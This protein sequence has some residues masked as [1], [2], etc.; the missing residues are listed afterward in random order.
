MS[1]TTGT[2]IFHCTTEFQSSSLTCC[3]RKV[4]NLILLLDPSLSMPV[5]ASSKACVSG[6]LHA[7]IV[8]LN[9]AGTMYLLCL[10]CV[11][12]CKVEVSTSGRS[13]IQRCPTE[14]GVYECDREA[15]IKRRPWPTGAVE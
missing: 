15:S 1:V 7:G 4:S 3:S 9:P 8:G 10:V 6:R 13:L 5:A 14:C 2:V 12:C 11:V